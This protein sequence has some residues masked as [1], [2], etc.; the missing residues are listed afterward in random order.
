[1]TAPRP[2][3]IHGLADALAALSTASELHRPLTLVSAPGAAAHA[4][5]LWFREVVA[6][7]RAA[8]PDVVVTAV[9]D[10]ADRA[11][12]VQG[13][14]ASG[15]THILFTG[16]PDAARALAE[17]AAARGAVLLQALPGALDLRTV[18]DPAAAC[19]AWLE[20]S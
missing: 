9:L 3:R 11:G 2:I 14:L 16:H 7:A 17:V 5:A 6:K 20:E 12:D 8:F 13:A 18:R 1:M 19:R 4:G 15:V 10:C